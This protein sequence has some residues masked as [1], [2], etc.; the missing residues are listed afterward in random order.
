MDIIIQLSH[1]IM[2]TINWVIT[3]VR[4]VVTDRTNKR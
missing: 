1:S 4:L 3:L 2:C